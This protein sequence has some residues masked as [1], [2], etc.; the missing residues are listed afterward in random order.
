VPASEVKDEIIAVNPSPEPEPGGVIRV[1]G[2]AEAC[3]VSD[4]SPKLRKI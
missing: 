3:V 1:A 4:S 2:F